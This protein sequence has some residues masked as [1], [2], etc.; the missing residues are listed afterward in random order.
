M[1]N[2]P[3][4]PNI[5]IVGLD[6][7]TNGRSCTCHANCSEY[8]FVDDVL[9]LAKGVV[10]VNGVTEEAI[11]LVKIKDARTPVRSLMCLVSLSI[12]QRL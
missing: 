8:V 3:E 5:D 7:L 11:K 12:Y 1:A 2:V 9:R 6:S 4:R 10:T